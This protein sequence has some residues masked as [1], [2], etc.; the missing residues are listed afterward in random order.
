MAGVAWPSQE[1]PVRAGGGSK[2]MK[3]GKLGED[4]CGHWRWG[5]GEVPV[6]G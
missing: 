5:R 1:M 3:E 2:A 6:V 4:G